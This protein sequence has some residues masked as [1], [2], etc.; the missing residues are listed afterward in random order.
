MHR[1]AVLAALPWECK[2]VLPALR[3]IRKGREEHCTWWCGRATVG[4]VIVVR[5]GIGMERTA[6][7]LPW[8]LQT[9]ACDLLVS[10][11]CAGGLMA[12]LSPGHVVVANEIVS[13]LSGASFS[14]PPPLV[15]ALVEASQQC[16]LKVATGR[17]L[18][19]NEALASVADKQHSALRF[20]AIAV[21]MESAA[22]AQ[23]AMQHGLPFVIVRSVL[24]PL[25]DP[26]PSTDGLVDPQTGRVRPA[27]LLSHV[28][29]NGMLGLRGLQELYAWKQ[30][31]EH[32][33]ARLFAHWLSTKDWLPLSAPQ[34]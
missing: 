24:D 12:V 26:L 18:C 9:F 34:N 30:C 19:V 21:D 4:E 32:A 16:G 31:A 3:K 11:G 33:L 13:A 23:A 7:A 27:R 15:A 17:Q 25:S 5:T 14:V 28:L 10:T 8:L 2:C 20:D 29:S 1:I 6:K 22:V